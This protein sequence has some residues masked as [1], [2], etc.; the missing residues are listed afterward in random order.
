MGGRDRAQAR[1]GEGMTR[2]TTRA[3]ARSVLWF[4]VVKVGGSNNKRRV[5]KRREAR[6][7]E[8]SW[9][10]TDEGHRRARHQ[11]KEGFEGTLQ[12]QMRMRDAG[13]TWK[14]HSFLPTYLPAQPTTCDN[15][16]TEY[17]S[18]RSLTRSRHVAWTPL[19]EAQRTVPGSKPMP[20]DVA[21]TEDH[22]PQARAKAES[23]CTPNKHT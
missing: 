6:R 10:K 7:G 4:L 18:C 2:K 14:T 5:E 12:L 17:T 20:D 9:W 8:D 3:M 15:E 11:E 13:T 21:W 1:S 23:E 22:Q 19:C 16:Y